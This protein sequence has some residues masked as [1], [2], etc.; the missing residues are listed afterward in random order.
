MLR[1][2]E[3]ALAVV[4]GR[5]RC[6]KSR[7]ILEA[8]PPE[9]AVYY[10]GDN[11]ESSLQR[12][13]LAREIGRLVPSFDKVTYPDWDA[14]FERW[15]QAAPRGASL[16]VDELPALVSSAT[17]VPSVLQRHVDRSGRGGPHLILAGS[18]QRMMHGLALDRTAPLFGRAREILRIA[19][20]PARYVGQ[21]LK[22]RSDVEAVEAYSVWGGIPRYW[23]LAAEYP[24]WQSA[25]E[26]LVLSPLGVLHEEPTALLVDDMRDTTQA[27]SILSLV[28]Q[29]A[30]RL[31]EIAGRLG[32]PAT[33]LSRPLQR[34]VEL[35][36]VVRESPF[37]AH[38][39]DSKRSSYK[40][41]DPFLRFWFRFVEPNRSKLEAGQI[42]QT[43]ECVEA[44]FP[45]HV[46]GVWEDLAR[47]SVA[48]VARDGHAWGPAKRWW[49][50]GL[51]RRPLE[52]DVVAESAD[53][54][55][56]LV[57]EVKWGD[58]TNVPGVLAELESKC[59]RLPIVGGRDVEIAVWV[60][61][62]R[63]RRRRN[64]FDAADV[65]GGSRVD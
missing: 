46:A 11:R 29:G 58:D 22:L 25:A 51:D 6:G 1:C 23:E 55:A 59:E 44:S 33:A 37:G 57:G 16:V 10:V 19:P 43:L 52:V 56:L 41:R 53:G 60:K 21:A 18:S 2:R 28:G 54:K 27:A 42:A 34:L 7:L 47:D 26:H 13:S 32:K 15:W 61:K 9:G 39:R 30:H 45:Q 40:L 65:M 36:L 5:R 48:R 38:P 14:L 49:G 17:E 4:Y 31:S 3:G 24:T 8:I 64:V 20:L 62:R 12:T 50:P 35:D 63:G